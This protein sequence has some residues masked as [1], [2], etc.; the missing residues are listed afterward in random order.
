MSNKQSKFISPNVPADS[1]ESTHLTIPLPSIL[2]ERINMEKANLEMQ[3]RRLSEQS[4]RILTVLL[5]GYLAGHPEAN[6]RNFE[7]SEDNTR[8]IEK[9]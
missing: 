4:D 5:E 2:I 9:L 1:G 3:I 7:L 6:G 8:L